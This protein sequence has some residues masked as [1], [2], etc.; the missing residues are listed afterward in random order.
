MS[1]D[2]SALEISWNQYQRAA[3]ETT[4]V[5]LRDTS[6]HS[7]KIVRSIFLEGDFNKSKFERSLIDT[8]L[9]LDQRHKARCSNLVFINSNLKLSDL[10]LS[11]SKARLMDIVRYIDHDFAIVIENVVNT[12][13]KF[14]HF[15]FKAIVFDA[16][17]V[18]LIT[19]AFFSHYAGLEAP[20]AIWDECYKNEMLDQTRASNST[21]NSSFPQLKGIDTLKRNTLN[22]GKRE[23]VLNQ[24][25][26]MKFQLDAG[27]YE[28][29]VRL[30]NEEKLSLHLIFLTCWCIYLN[31][32]TSKKAMLIATSSTGRRS[33]KLENV[34]GFYYEIGYL[35]PTLGEKTEFRKNA[36]Q[37]KAAYIK[38]F[39]VPD[40]KNSSLSQYGRKWLLAED[41]LTLVYQHK[42]SDETYREQLF[43]NTKA[44]ILQ[45]EYVDTTS[46][47][48]SLDGMMSTRSY[49]NGVIIEFEF[50][51]G[52]LSIQDGL[53]IVQGFKDIM[54]T[55][56]RPERIVSV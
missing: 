16:Y 51:K 23:R 8:L 43:C 26:K 47:C 55:V 45:T 31:S 24:S 21:G 19:E 7:L 27:V 17:S 11:H 4:E 56:S 53:T 30:A 50:D 46:Y 22:L 20:K 52:T 13:C 38:H 29:I 42:H 41:S 5:R 49:K 39:S 36:S 28:N 40:T 33:G 35:A 3:A 54:A 6:I 14:V 15:V 25:Q 34:L 48:M 44:K 1:V 12:E 32:F 10:A 9:G 37:V 2:Q 18:D